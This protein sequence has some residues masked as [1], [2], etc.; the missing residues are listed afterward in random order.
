MDNCEHV[1]AAA[2]EAIAA[3]LARSRSITVV[4]TTRE[5]LTLDGETV[6][7]VPPLALEGGAASDAVSLFVDRART[8]RP[9]FG[10][11]ERD[12]ADAVTEICESLDGLP[13]GIELAAAR[14]AAMS[15]VEVR[16]RLADRFRL[17]RGSAG[18]ERQ[19]TLTDAVAWSYDLLTDDEQELL[20]AAS[21]F[22]GGFTLADVCAALDDADD[23]DVLRHLDSLV[24]K[25]LV[26][27][28]H[29]ASRTRYGLFETIRQFAEDRLGEAGALAATRDR[30]A[31]HFAREAV[32]RW[33][34]W[35]GPGW[36]DAVDWVEVELG[37][38]RAGYRWSAAR[39]A[40]DV[41]TD[42]A[43]H[44]ALMGFSVELFETLAWAEELLV[45][46]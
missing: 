10:L 21:V 26:V 39:G 45:P 13:L 7:A 44:A 25:S 22:A 24:R 2:G 19:L 16:D 5:T 17:L 37:N 29:T 27:A 36:R 4:A 41:A 28:D 12:T 14:M 20:R 3:M 23:I 15:A 30:H 40:L 46:A 42:I 33:E 1:V 18:P 9:E 11:G 31:A 43:A 35:N 32:A 6:F 34:H 8:V 38:L